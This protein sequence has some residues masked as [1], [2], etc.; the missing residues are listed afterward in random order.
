MGSGFLTSQTLNSKRG[1]V[2]KRLIS[3]SPAVIRFRNGGREAKARGRR[4]GKDRNAEFEGRL[5]QQVPQLSSLFD[6]GN[7]LQ[8]QWQ[9]G[10][11]EGRRKG[12]KRTETEGG[13]QG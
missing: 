6:V 8:R 12:K 3:P 13:R 1:D 10:K 7:T 5:C 9:R 11:G 2:S 4:K